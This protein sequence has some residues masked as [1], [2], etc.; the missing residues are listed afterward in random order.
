MDAEE[1]GERLRTLREAAGFSQ[2]ELAKRAGV[3]N[4]TIS[5]IET[6]KVS[7]TVAKLKKV[8]DGIP[9]SVVE[10]FAGP[11]LSTQQVFYRGEDLPNVGAADVIY[12]LVGHDH[13]D[14]QLCLM[15][16]IYPPEAD[17]GKE[18]IHHQG[19]EGGVVV[20]GHIEMTI[21]GETQ[22]LGP[23]D[24]YYFDTRLPHRIRCVGDET[25]EVVSASTPPTY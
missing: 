4:A 25:A 7:P 9:I 5:L 2:R 10:F 17:T 6:N 23:G 19:E 1:I 20:R 8:L 13:P 21:D 22:R 18:M 14:R 11:S 15:H 12:R 16:E 3:T 24:A